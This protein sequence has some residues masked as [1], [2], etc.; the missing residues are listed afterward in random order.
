MVSL[1]ANIATAYM[2]LLLAEGQ[3]QVAGQ[4]IETQTK[5]HSITETRYECGLVSKLDVAQS[6]TVPSGSWTACR[7][8]SPTECTITW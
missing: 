7:S 4:Q 8:I 6:L 1:A 3:I 5:I 2:N